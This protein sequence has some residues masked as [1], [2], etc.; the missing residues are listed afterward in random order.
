VQPP[1]KNEDSFK[2]LGGLEYCGSTDLHS[3]RLFLSLTQAW[4]MF[5]IAVSSRSAPSIR[6]AFRAIV[7]KD[8]R[9]PD[10]DGYFLMQSLS[11]SDHPKPASD[12]HLKTG[13]R[14]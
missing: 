8:D 6:R 9:L 7:A 5:F 12:Y 11:L 14:E 4:F 3:S 1:E 2:I 10:Y 13:Q